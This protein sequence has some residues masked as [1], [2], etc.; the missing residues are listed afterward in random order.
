MM[1]A[2]L[3]VAAQQVDQTTGEAKQE[4]TTEKSDKGKT[5]KVKKTPEE[6][7]A[8]KKAKEEA[9]KAKKAE[10]E[11]SKQEKT[12]DDVDKKASDADDKLQQQINLLITERDQLKQERDDYAQKLSDA[13][14]EMDRLKKEVAA[15]APFR[16]M[17][18][19]QTLADAAAW[20]QLPL[21]QLNANDVQQLLDDC[22]RYGGSNKEF[23][24]AAQQLEMMHSELQQFN[25]ARQL[26]ELPYDKQA[27]DAA[28]A[29]LKPLIGKHKGKPQ[30]EEISKIDELLRDYDG[31]VMSFQDL[32]NK[33]NS[34]L[35]DCRS[36]SNKVMAANML[37]ACLEEKE[38]QVLITDICT[39]PYLKERLLNEM[40]GYLPIL[41]K[42]PLKHWKE[43]ARILEMLK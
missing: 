39:I 29:Q 6:K 2:T 42:D 25:N 10:K 35:E 27:K 7:E 31:Y 19:K 8:E 5:A 12:K 3:P 26:L 43:E 17:K 41:R 32:I 23:R 9:R 4:Q 21:S 40:D 24:E 20:S 38:Q 15:L 37:E 36:N 33:V 22:R 1:T 16:E 13:Q 11:K 34:E 14:G 28:R 18:L 30:G